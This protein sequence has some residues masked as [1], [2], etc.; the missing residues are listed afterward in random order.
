PARTSGGQLGE[1]L[2]YLVRLTQPV[3]IDDD[4]VL[5]GWWTGNAPND[6]PSP[7]WPGGHGNL[8]IAH[9]V[10]G[11]LALLSL[12]ARDGIE[13]AGQREA[14]ERICEWLDHWRTGTGTQA[15]WPEL[16]SRREHEAGTST[17]A[18]PGRPSWCYGTPG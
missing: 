1:V 10:A 16:V 7:D 6:E 17:Q 2:S 11:P 12:A 5:P 3:T 14:I 13:V 15:W 4:T 8:G 9:G 18:G